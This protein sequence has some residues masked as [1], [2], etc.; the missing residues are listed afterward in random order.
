MKIPTYKS[1]LTMTAASPSVESNIQLDPSQ[2]IYKATKSVT[3]F[4]KD[5]QTILDMRQVGL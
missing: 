4:L 1:K 2:N 3:N 5:E